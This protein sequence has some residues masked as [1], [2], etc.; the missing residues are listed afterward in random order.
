MKILR[1]LNTLDR[2]LVILL[3]ALVLFFVFYF[4]VSD[5][6]IAYTDRAMKNYIVQQSQYKLSAAGLSIISEQDIADDQAPGFHAV[7]FSSDDQ[8]TV[9]IALF[10]IPSGKKL[11]PAFFQEWAVD[12][13]DLSDQIFVARHV[14]VAQNDQCE[15]YD[16]ILNLDPNITTINKMEYITYTQIS[17]VDSRECIT[18]PCIVVFPYSIGAAHRRSEYVSV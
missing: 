14:G 5:E 11:R 8:Q 2:V 7:A 1:S 4:K 9:G 6:N 3:I 16:V 12:L 17:C 10:E 13:T 18:S 15:F